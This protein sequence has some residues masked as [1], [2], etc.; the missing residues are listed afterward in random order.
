MEIE[1]EVKTFC[2]KCNKHTVHSVKLYSKGPGF[3]IGMNIG[4]RRNVR[5]RKGIKGKV[6]GQATM[7]KISK[8]QKALLKCKVCSYTVEKVFGT[9]TKKK[10]EVKK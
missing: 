10:L 7:K 5:K 6:K 2:P 9:R 1:K 8:K 4:N 3:G